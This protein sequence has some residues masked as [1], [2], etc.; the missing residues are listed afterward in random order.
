MKFLCIILVLIL[1]ACATPTP[2]TSMCR[3]RAVECA[4]DYVEVYGNENTGVAIGPSKSTIW[5]AQA[6]IKHPGIEWLVNVG[7]ECEIGDME[8]FTPQIFMST[9]EFLH[10]QF[11]EV[12]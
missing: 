4:L 9:E 3:Q 2:I 5:H 11:S 7:Y 10:W 8:D 12:K 6:F 1:T